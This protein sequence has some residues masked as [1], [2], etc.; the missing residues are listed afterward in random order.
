[1]IVDPVPPSTPT[2]SATLS[3]APTPETNALR[4]FGLGTATFVVVAS[5]IGSGVLTTSGYT[6]YSVGSNQLML[7]LWVVGGL[8]AI[9]GAL[10]IAELA[11]SL[12]ESGGDYV[13][14]REAYGPLAAFL[15]GWVSF[16]IGFGG[17]I[18]VSASASGRYFLEPWHLADSTR[19]WAQNA[20]ATAAIVLLAFIH[21]SGHRQGAIAQAG[22]T[23][24]K[25]GV[26]LVLAIGGLIAGWGHWDHLDDR[27]PLDT[28]RWMLMFSS[29]IYVSYA[30][31]GWNAAGYIA[32]RLSPQGTPRIA[33]WLQVAWSIVLLWSGTLENLLS[34][35]SVGLALISLLSISSIYVLRH[36][37]PKLH[38]PFR[39]PGY[40]VVPAVYLLGTG[41]LTAAAFQKSPL[42][43]S[44]ALASIL[45]GIP[46]YYLFVRRHSAAAAPV[47][48]S[49]SEPDLP[50][51]PPA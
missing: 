10:T 13:F 47:L 42:V 41:L 5:M 6:V 19:W 23:I 40:P 16:L 45:L 51:N 24:I 9:C 43:S 11:A 1:M 32:G 49:A 25:W 39:T 35:S 26:L 27:P 17:P 21:A 15:S 31:T 50:V 18:A 20:I 22:T 28:T 8:L 4:R 44:L 46:F 12:P 14:L 36:R 37:L 48:V 7:G 38:R 33:T 2:D 30:Y 3:P 34:Y 29:L